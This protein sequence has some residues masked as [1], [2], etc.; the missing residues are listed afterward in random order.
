M[1]V[2]D[3]QTGFQATRSAS[4]NRSGVHSLETGPP[5]EIDAADADRLGTA[6]Q[7]KIGGHLS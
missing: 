3:T 4:E 2:T 6:T 1:C 7:G 5:Y